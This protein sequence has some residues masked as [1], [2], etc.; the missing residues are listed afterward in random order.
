MTTRAQ[1]LS[2][3]EEL[4]VALRASETWEESYMRSPA[5]LKRLVRQEARLQRHATEYLLGLAE[6]ILSLVNWNEVQPQLRASEVPL[7]SDEAFVTERLF[8]TAAIGD[9]ILELT[10]IGAQAGEEIYTR[11]LSITSLD[12]R[13]VE[14]AGKQ[15]AGAVSQITKTTRKLIQRAIKQSIV[16]GEDAAALVERIRKYVSNPVRAEMIAQTESV[17]AYQGGLEVFGAE[18]GVKSW[19]WDALSKACELCA[20]LD[21]VTKPVGKMFVGANGKEVLHPPL[22]TRCRCGRIANY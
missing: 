9:D 2:A 17:T 19:T 10:V 16:N 3:H 8:L 22:H 5:T 6:R 4:T 1:L 13:V 20:P 12:D 14:A 11:P 7:D 15:T 18:S 21:G